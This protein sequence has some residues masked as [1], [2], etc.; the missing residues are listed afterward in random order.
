MLS[1]AQSSVFRTALALPRCTNSTS[2]FCGATV[3]QSKLF[4][5]DSIKLAT[6]SSSFGPRDPMI[7]KASP[8]GVVA[9]TTETRV[10]L[11]SPSVQCANDYCVSEQDWMKKVN[12]HAPF[13]YFQG[14]PS[15]A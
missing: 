5:L 3:D 11:K 1:F 7:N 10:L 9:R 12:F 6:V 4:T 2:Q 8:P 14:C 15:L 13:L